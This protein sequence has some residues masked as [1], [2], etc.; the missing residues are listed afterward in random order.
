MGA[1]S[2]QFK[3]GDGCIFLP[4]AASSGVYHEIVRI[5]CLK[6]TIMMA[7][8]ILLNDWRMKHTRSIDVT[9]EVEIFV[10]SASFRKR[11]WANPV[12]LTGMDRV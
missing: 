5:P 3:P 8:E 10:T 12:D 9:T 7:E 2:H 11:D 6:L 1:L 4:L